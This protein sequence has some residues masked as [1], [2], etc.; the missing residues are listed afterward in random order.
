MLSPPQSNSDPWKT[1]VLIQMP[2][3]KH[4]QSP[5]FPFDYDNWCLR[6]SLSYIQIQSKF[7]CKHPFNGSSFLFSF[8]YKLRDTQHKSQM[9]IFSPHDANFSSLIIAHSWFKIL[10]W[11]WKR[12]TWDIMLSFWYVCG[13]AYSELSNKTLQTSTIYVAETATT[14]YFCRLSSYI[15]HKPVY[16]ASVIGL[17]LCMCGFGL[18]TMFFAP[19]LWY[20]QCLQLKSSLEFSSYLIGKL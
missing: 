11:W 19:L 20:V 16:L 5:T 3:R 17:V 12:R 10:G 4:Y 18:S 13:F 6:N 1:V 2:G 7:G 14:F 8:H 9:Y 15:G